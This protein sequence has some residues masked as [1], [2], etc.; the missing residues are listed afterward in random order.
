MLQAGKFQLK[1][2]CTPSA[3]MRI[4]LLKKELIPFCKI[5]SA[6]PIPNPWNAMDL[7]IMYS[8]QTNNKKRCNGYRRPSRSKKNS[9]NLKPTFILS[10]YANAMTNPDRIKKKSTKIALR[11]KKAY[12]LSITNAE[13]N[14]ATKIAAIPLNDSN[15]RYFKNYPKE[16]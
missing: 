6:L 7:T 8:S 13:W 9:L 3:L 5:G 15:D 11:A 12:L 2:S 14:K 4:K 10:L 16:R 1:D